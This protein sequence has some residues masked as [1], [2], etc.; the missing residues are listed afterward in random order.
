MH[1][2]QHSKEPWSPS[3]AITR[4]M[5]SSGWLSVALSQAGMSH[6]AV[7]GFEVA[8]LPRRLSSASVSTGFRMLNVGASA[9][10]SMFGGNACAV[11]RASNRQDARA[12]GSGPGVGTH[13]GLKAALLWMV[14]GPRQEGAGAGARSGDERQTNQQRK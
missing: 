14:H 8:R 11:V 13:G 4:K 2:K 7:Q 5:G 12:V 1:L 9:S 3:P 10:S 6:N